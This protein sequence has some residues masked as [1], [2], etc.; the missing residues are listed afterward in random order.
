MEMTQLDVKN[1]LEKIYNVHS[2]HVRTRIALGK[3][4]IPIN[5]KFVAKK[6]DMK[7]AYVTLVSIKIKTQFLTKIY[8]RY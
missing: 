1:Y 7:I 4:Y 6:D 5:F 8:L 3:T 2:V